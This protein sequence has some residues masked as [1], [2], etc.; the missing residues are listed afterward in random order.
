[1]SPVPK[2]ERFPPPKTYALEEGTH[3]RTES[4]L[5]K[6]PES[7]GSKAG[8]ERTDGKRPRKMDFRQ[9][10]Y[11]KDEDWKK[12]VMPDENLLLVNEINNKLVVE[13]VVI[14][15]LVKNR[16]VLEYMDKASKANC[17][18]TRNVRVGTFRFKAAIQR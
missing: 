9:C 14:R 13:L 2:A 5:K 17:E 10:V 4:F 7:Q 8:K 3:P 16:S 15:H 18:Y 12:T 1:M 11:I 6:R